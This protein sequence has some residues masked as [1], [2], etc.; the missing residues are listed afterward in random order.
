[1][2]F[3]TNSQGVNL[4]YQVKPYD[5]KQETHLDVQIWSKYVL[6]NIV[7]DKPVGEFLRY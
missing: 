2:I 7:V 6:Y 1:M 4:T 5:L 3:L